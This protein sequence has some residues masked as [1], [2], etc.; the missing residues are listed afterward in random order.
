[1]LKFTKGGKFLQQFGRP[2]KSA[3]SHDLDNFRGITEGFYYARTNEMFLADGEYNRRVIVVD[4]DTGQYKRHWG[5][6]GNT[7]DDRAPN[8]RT[9]VG[10]GPPQWNNVHSILISHD[11]IVY[12]SEHS[13]NRIHLFKPDGTFINE[14]WVDRHVA[15][16]TGTTLDLAFSPDQDQQFIFASGGDQRVR[17]LRRDTFE[18]V[19]IIGRLGH[20]AGQFH[21][22]HTLAVDS[23]GNLYTGDNTG[24]RVQKFV[25]TGYVTH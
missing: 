2:G 16:P 8:E 13:G 18:V 21:H 1:M 10:E 20:Y 17:I 12:V 19:G 6:Y 9:F 24:K 23:H 11:D 4:A 5:A 7:P 22:L 25:I 3:G 14:V 15:T